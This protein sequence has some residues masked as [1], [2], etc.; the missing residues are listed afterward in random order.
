MKHVA[1][2]DYG[3]LQGYIDFYK[4]RLGDK[5]ITTLEEWENFVGLK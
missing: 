4:T 1:S 5:K 2:A 3:I